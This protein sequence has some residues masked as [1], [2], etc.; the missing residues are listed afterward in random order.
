MHDIATF[1]HGYPPFDAL[2]EED[3]AAVAGAVEIEF[4]AAGALIS[5]QGATPADSVRVVRRGAVELVV[6]D[7]PF[8]L[9]G[10]GEAFGHASML[11]GLP[12]ALGARAA[13]DTLLYRVPETVIAPLL[14]RPEGL[15]FIARSLDAR[16][17]LDPARVMGGGD[18]VAR[19]AGDLVRSRAVSVD[20][21][22]TI[23]QAAQAMTAANATSAVVPLGDGTL[24]I[25]TDR[26]LRRRVVAE[27]RSTDDAVSTIMSAPA[28]TVT[29]DRSGSEVLLE[30]LDRGVR[31][32]PVLDA[33]GALLG[34][35]ADTDLL[36][37]EART[38]FHLRSAIARAETV[39]AVQAAARRLPETVISLLDA[40][41]APTAISTTIS[42][43]LDAL[44]RRL[45]DLAVAEHGPPPVPF[46][47][48]AL[49]SHARRECVPSSDLDS[50]L[51]WHG[52]DEDVTIKRYVRGVARDVI[53]ALDGAGYP[54]CD[55]GASASMP[56]FSRSLDAWRE[57]AES[58]LDDPDQEAALIL[59]SVVID[60]R[61]VWGL[62]EGAPLAEAFRNARDSPRLLKGLVRFALVHRPPTGF[63]RDIVVEHSGEHRGKLDIK[64][65]GLLPIADIAR[66]VGM[67]AGV[68]GASTR[69]RL[70][71]AAGAGTI[72]ANEAQTL[73]EAFELFSCMR[74]E[75]QVEQL[76]DGRPPDDFLDPRRLNGLTRSYLKDAFRAVASIQ[77]Q[78]QNEI[79]LR[80]R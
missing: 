2:S 15:R 27:G 31:H 11:S 23:R 21:A 62:R 44:T 32:F 1:L 38:P 59:V 6:D 67:A 70:N 60:S 76:R 42:V 64:G 53:A 78:L 40:Q 50:A 57:A 63:L 37:V 29:A 52:D 48:L 18:P 14:S 16:R 36:A 30:M 12:Q 17:G 45:V 47:W 69:E 25:V 43:V 71:A 28:Y 13:E 80:L 73:L 19:R 49:G 8:D 20:A 77:K 7:R 5:P 34:V 10:E 9:L 22:T 39:D 74:L 75:H 24:G 55:K 79:A 41:V 66:Y 26:D 68:T 65:G 56:L 3:L 46:S 58:W 61:P 33:R 54:P 72:G 51:L 35:L 4:F